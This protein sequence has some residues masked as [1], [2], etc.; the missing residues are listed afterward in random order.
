MSHRPHRSIGVQAVIALASVT[1]A[2]AIGPVQPSATAL[3][4][5][6]AQNAAPA[7]NGVVAR[8]E[9]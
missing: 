2:G 8:F 3:Q 1:T 9:N 4:P 5:A 6:P 7:P